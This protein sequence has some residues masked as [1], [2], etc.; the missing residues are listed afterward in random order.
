ML[1]VLL[2]DKLFGFAFLAAFLFWAAFYFFVQSAGLQADIPVSKM[3][4]AVLVY[5]VLEE[6]AFRGW[7]QGKLLEW[8]PGRESWRGISQANLLTSLAF[9]GIHFFYYSWW[10]ALAV[11]VPSL[12]FGFFREKY[13]SILPGCILHSWYNAGYYLLAFGV[14]G[15]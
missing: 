12:V 3:L 10:W 14:V 11:I 5:P 9:V 13:Q 2:S 7:L 1:R 8:H 6:T 15:Y 4:L